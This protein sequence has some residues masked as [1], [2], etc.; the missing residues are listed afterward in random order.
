MI[1]Q[2]PIHPRVFFTSGSD[3]E[4]TVVFKRDLEE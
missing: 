3:F 4:F 1:D 2:I